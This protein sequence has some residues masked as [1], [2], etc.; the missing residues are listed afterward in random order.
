MLKYDFYTSNGHEK[1]KDFIENYWS[2]F[3]AK[4]PNSSVAAT[5]T[6]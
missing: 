5:A 4:H 2:Q 6:R 3:Q 1:Q